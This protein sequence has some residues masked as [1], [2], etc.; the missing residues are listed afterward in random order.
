MQ[1]FPLI[2]FHS[3]AYLTYL[4]IYLRGIFSVWGYRAI[5]RLRGS[6]IERSIPNPR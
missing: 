2:Q 4:I 5:L 1:T 3:A 6:R